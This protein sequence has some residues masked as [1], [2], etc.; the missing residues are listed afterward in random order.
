MSCNF[1]NFLLGEITC[2]S[3]LEI[4][5]A[6]LITLSVLLSHLLVKGVLWGTKLGVK[7]DFFVHSI[8]LTSSGIEPKYLNIKHYC[9]VKLLTGNQLPRNQHFLF[10]IL[11]FQGVN[12]TKMQI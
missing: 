8:C 2:Q 6:V 1:C 12:G 10:F 7:P 3:V 9:I 4:E 11:Y 5:K